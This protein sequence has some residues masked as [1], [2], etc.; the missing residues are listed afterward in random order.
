MSCMPNWECKRFILEHKKRIGFVKPVTQ[1]LHDV[2]PDNLQWLGVLFGQGSSKGA[3][4]ACHQI[5]WR[6]SR[7]GGGR[8]PY[9]RRRQNHHTSGHLYFLY[10]QSQPFILHA[11][12]LSCFAIH[13]LSCLSK[14]EVRKVLRDGW[15]NTPER[16][17]KKSKHLKLGWYE[18]DVS[19]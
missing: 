6:A 1:T 2:Q 4:F 18:Q 16:I 11:M 9:Q 7:V 13:K 14:R 19:A 12:A 10:L 15:N 8:K 5:F 17:P 3:T